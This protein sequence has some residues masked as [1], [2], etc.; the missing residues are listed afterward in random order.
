[1]GWWMATLVLRSWQQFMWRLSGAQELCSCQDGALPC[2][3]F[4]CC[5]LCTVGAARMHEAAPAFLAVSCCVGERPVSLW[6]WHKGRRDRISFA[7]PWRASHASSHCSESTGRHFQDLFGEANPEVI[8]VSHSLLNTENKTLFKTTKAF[9]D[10][11]H[12]K[13]DHLTLHNSLK[14]HFTQGNKNNSLNYFKYSCKS[15]T[16][17]TFSKALNRSLVDF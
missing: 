9:N 2:W 17:L 10:L 7:L 6:E 12:I 5:L 16:T 3:S 15:L 13:T 4:L 1:M 8:A 11:F 14:F